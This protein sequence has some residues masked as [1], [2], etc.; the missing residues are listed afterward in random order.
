VLSTDVLVLHQTLLCYPEEASRLV[1]NLHVL[2]ERVEVGGRTKLGRTGTKMLSYV[3]VCLSGPLGGLC[4]REEISKGSCTGYLAR[5]RAPSTVVLEGA[6]GYSY[7]TLTT[8]RSKAIIPRMSE[9]QRLCWPTRDIIAVDSD[10]FEESLATRSMISNTE[11]PFLM[12]VL[13]EPFPCS[14]LIP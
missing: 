14:F 9:I 13:A 1:M 2:L 6:Q 3:G 12:P 7:P 8:D 10:Y 11:T 5:N 4:L